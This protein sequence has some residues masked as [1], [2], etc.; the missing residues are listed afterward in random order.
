MQSA[1][2]TTAY[3]DLAPELADGIAQDLVTSRSPDWIRDVAERWVTTESNVTAIAHDVANGTFTFN[4]SLIFESPPTP[5]GTTTMGNRSATQLTTAEVQEITKILRVNG[6]SP[7]VLAKVI[8]QYNI[9]EATGEAF[10][11]VISEPAPKSTAK[12]TEGAPPPGMSRA[13]YE[14]AVELAEGGEPDMTGLSV[15]DLQSLTE[16]NYGSVM[17]PNR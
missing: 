3:A 15:G 4:E 5:K 9:T 11:K 7:T 17:F 13:V 1:A 16:L 8:K 6:P 12:V 14:A 2:F 10:A